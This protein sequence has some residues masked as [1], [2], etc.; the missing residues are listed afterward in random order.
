M[1]KLE[2]EEE[3]RQSDEKREEF[4]NFVEKALLLH[5]SSGMHTFSLT[6]KVPSHG[7]QP[8][9]NSWIYSALRHKVQKMILCL[10]FDH[11]RGS[12]MLPRHLFACE[13]L[14]QL[15][16]DFLFDLRLPSFVYLP[17]LKVLSLSGVIFM[18]DIS[19]EQLFQGCPKLEQL[20]LAECEWD[21]VEAVHVYGP[22]LEYLEIIESG[23][24]EYTKRDCQFLISG[25]RL[26][27]FH[28]TGELINENCISD[29]PSLVDA[30][31]DMYLGQIDMKSGTERQ[32]AYRAHKL[33]MALANVKILH[34]SSRAF[35]VLTDAEDLVP[36]LPLFPNLNH[37]EVTRGALNFD[38]RVLLKILHNSPH[39]ESINFAMGI[40][41]S[42][43]SMRDGWRLDPVPLC[44]LTQLKTIKVE[45]FKGGEEEVNALK[46]ILK[47]ARV[48][49]RIDLGSK[50]ENEIPN[51]ILDVVKECMSSNGS[52]TLKL[53]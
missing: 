10:Y 42:E 15:E 48:V 12:F 50:K 43:S 39:L 5:N 22:M 40:H 34:L 32:A 17:N 46:T 45:N 13:S 18:D 27:I 7:H 52:F 51:V 36:F 2:F 14:K 35:H 11:Y 47:S 37:L 41:F 25:P 21:N 16:L 26:K 9:I 30:H 19:V 49:E 44:F 38:C 28:F 20:E 23:A 4:M 53:I 31:L 1:S 3:F 33:L 24:N 6:C 8:R 29:A